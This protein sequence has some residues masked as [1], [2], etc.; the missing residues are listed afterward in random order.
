MEAGHGL[1]AVKWVHHFG[2]RR[3]GGGTLIYCDV[4]GVVRYSSKRAPIFYRGIYLDWPS[5]DG[6]SMFRIP[7]TKLFPFKPNL[8][9]EM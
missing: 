2:F 1:K 3:G 6:I 5:S 4:H 7:V 8:D 9:T